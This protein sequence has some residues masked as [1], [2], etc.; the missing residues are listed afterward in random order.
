LFWPASFVTASG[1]AICGMGPWLVT[2]SLFMGAAAAEASAILRTMAL[3]FTYNLVSL[4][5]AMIEVGGDPASYDRKN[6][7]IVFYTN[8]TKE[9]AHLILARE[10]AHHIQQ[11]SP[12]FSGLTNDQGFVPFREGMA[13]GYEYHVAAQLGDDSQLI[14]LINHCE[15]LSGLLVYLVKKEGVP[16]CSLHRN[17]RDVLERIKS[18]VSLPHALGYGAF[19]LAEQKHGTDI[20]RKVFDG[21]VSFLQPT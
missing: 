12:L 21:D 17:T 4:G 20:Y 7:M 6:K 18:P 11:N 10:G 1:L 13:I 16:Y 15:L 19:Y 8:P 3:R 14:R 2:G 9:E 5:E